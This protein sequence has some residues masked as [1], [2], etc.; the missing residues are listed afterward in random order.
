MGNGVSGDEYLQA[1]ADHEPAGTRE[2]ADAVGVARQS[3]EYRL[4]Q[5]RDAGRVESKKIG[6]VLVWMLPD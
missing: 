3:A 6:G 5:L 1:V 4:K 2:V